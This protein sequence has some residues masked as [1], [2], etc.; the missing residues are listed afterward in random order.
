MIIIS[1]DQRLLTNLWFFD[2]LVAALKNEKVL[3]IGAAAIGSQQ[4]GRQKIN[5]K[6]SGKGFFW[7]RPPS[8]SR[9][10]WSEMKKN[11]LRHG[12]KKTDKVEYF[13]SRD[14][15]PTAVSDSKGTV[16]VWP[17]LKR[18]PPSNTLITNTGDNTTTEP[19]PPAH[20]YISRHHNLRVPTIG[21]LQLLSWPLAKIVGQ[22]HN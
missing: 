6:R 12:L 22:G 4:S 13:T 19:P 14:G 15:R 7:W 5:G 16:A 20:H 11:W 2:H 18:R 1:T 8:C 9:Q 3:V 21:L 10:R 17:T